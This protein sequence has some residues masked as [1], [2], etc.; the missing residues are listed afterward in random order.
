MIMMMGI[1]II[2][3]Y[4]PINFAFISFNKYE[5][6]EHQLKYKFLEMNKLIFELQKNILVLITSILILN[7][8]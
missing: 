7:H 8:L 1:I 6:L 5:N 2:K 4:Y 3:D